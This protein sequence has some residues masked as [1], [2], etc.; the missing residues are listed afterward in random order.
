VEVKIMSDQTGSESTPNLTPETPQTPAA[1]PSISSIDQIP[2]NLRNQLEAN[3]KRGLQSELAAARQQLEQLN[4]L[5]EQTASLYDLLGDKVQLEEGSDLGDV[6]FQIGGTLENLKT[7]K[8]KMEAANMKQAELL[9]AAQKE[10]AD[11]RSQYHNTMI[12]NDL[13]AQLGGDR[14]V[15][16]IAAELIAERFSKV[17]EVGDDGTVGFKMSVTDENGHTAEQVISAS[18]AVTTLE[19]QKEWAKLFTATVNSGAGG[20][21]VD[22]VKRGADGKVDLNALINDP[23]KYLEIMNTNPDLIRD[24]IS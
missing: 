17:A 9:T 22:N 4:T 8:E 7:E 14:T 2:Q 16:P 13:Y 3:H 18:E 21:V 20:E 5:K 11:Y 19:S 1:A 12:K 23:Q 24:A 6:A 10:A 15:S